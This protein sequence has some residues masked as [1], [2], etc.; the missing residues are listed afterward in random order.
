M[1]VQAAFLAAGEEKETVGKLAAQLRQAHEQ[2]HAKQ[3]GLDDLGAPPHRHTPSP[4]RWRTCTV[5]FD[6]TGGALLT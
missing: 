1:Q 4:A 5:N 6:R 3:K 2:S